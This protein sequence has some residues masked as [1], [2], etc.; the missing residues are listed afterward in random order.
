MT[1]NGEYQ[2][3]A[4]GW[5]G[6]LPICRLHD[7]LHA[8]PDLG[9]AVGL[10]PDGRLSMRFNPHLGPDDTGRF[11]LASAAVDLFI[12]ARQ[13]LTVLIRAGAMRIEFWEDKGG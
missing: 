9:A 2:P 7:F 6:S 10:A 12:A 13:D 5:R 1:R 3:G 4:E 11:A 8:N